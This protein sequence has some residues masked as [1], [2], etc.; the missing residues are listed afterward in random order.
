MSEQINLDKSSSIESYFFADDWRFPC[1]QLTV[2]FTSSNMLSFNATSEN[3]ITFGKSKWVPFSMK[4]TIGSA[5]N[6]Y[7]CKCFPANA[8]KTASTAIGTSLELSSALETTLSLTSMNIPFD[9]PTKGKMLVNLA[10]QFRYQSLLQNYK[11]KKESTFLYFDSETLYSSTLSSL[12]QQTAKS[13]TVTNEMNPIVSYWDDRL[14]SQYLTELTGPLDYNE[15]LEKMI[16]R[17]VVIDSPKA[18]NILSL[19]TIG[20]NGWH[21]ELP[22]M[23]CLGCNIDSKRQPNVYSIIFGELITDEQ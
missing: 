17:I 19:Y 20:Q 23:L 1:R 9:V 12:L 10:T 6:G 7:Q 13:Y 11:N 15:E 4:E 14:N 22:K 3:Y 21:N 2:N 18:A 5:C 8:F 16:G